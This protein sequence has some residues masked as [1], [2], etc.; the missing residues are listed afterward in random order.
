MTWGR[1]AR[2]GALHM[3]AQG[4]ENSLPPPLP[5]ALVG[6][7]S[8]LLRLACTTALRAGMGS[9][10]H[11]HHRFGSWPIVFVRVQTLLCSSLL[12]RVICTGHFGVPSIVTDRG[13][14]TTFTVTVK[15]TGPGG[16][17]QRPG[18]GSGHGSG[19]D[20]DVIRRASS[21]CRR[22]ATRRAGRP[23]RGRGRT[24]TRA[25]PARRPTRARRRRRGCRERRRGAGRGYLR[26]DLR[27]A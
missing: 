13:R 17:S 20:H 12:Q 2:P 15:R 11:V 4:A 26:S 27:A 7:S 3:K 14:Q 21:P 16:P 24:R 8:P 6:R 10:D 23:R 9:M 18:H 5:L 22:R 25:R 19:A 1:E